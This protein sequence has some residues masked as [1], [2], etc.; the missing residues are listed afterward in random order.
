MDE[1]LQEEMGDQV[2][3]VEEVILYD[4]SRALTTLLGS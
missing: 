2:E 4:I 3:E 1:A